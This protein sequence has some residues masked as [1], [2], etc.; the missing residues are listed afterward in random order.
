[1]N[2]SST[3]CWRGSA[4]STAPCSWSTRPRAGAPSPPSTSPCSTCSASLPGWSPSARPTC[5]TLPPSRRPRGRSPTG[6]AAPPWRARRSCPPQ[7]CPDRL[8]RV[9]SGLRRCGLRSTTRSAGRPSRLTWGGRGCRSTGCSRRVGAAR[10]SPAPSQAGP[11]PPTSRPSCCR[12]AGG[13]ASAHCRGTARRWPGLSPPAAW[14]STWRA[15]PP[16]RWRAATCWC[17]PASGRRPGRQTAACA[18]WPRLLPRSAP[19]APT[20]ST[21]GP[22]RP[23]CACSRS[24]CAR[25]RRAARRWSA[26]T[27]SGR[28]CSTSWK[29]WCCATAAATRRSAAAASSTPTLRAASTAPPCGYGAW[30]SWRPGSAPAARACLAACWPSAAQLR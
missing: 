27:W 12:R 23:P 3:T 20:C 5:A 26:S 11:S 4:G 1:M 22:R 15:S 2:A 21:P 29:R 6:F 19:A 16:P 25:S 18:A 13:Y 28:W 9:G 30:R 14:R 8:R 24:T 17:C 10:W 7:C